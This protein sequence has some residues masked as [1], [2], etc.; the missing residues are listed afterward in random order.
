[1]LISYHYFIITIKHIS[2]KEIEHSKIIMELQQR[3]QLSDISFSKAFFQD[4]VRE[5][6]FITTMMK[7]Y[8]AAQLKILSEISNIC[9]RHSINWFA[10]CGTLIG[11]V[12]HGGYVPWDDDMDIC[13]LRSDWNRFF[14]VAKE[15]LP[16]GYEVL[17]IEKEVEYK[18]PI[19]RIVNSHAID[20]SPSH[21][22]KFYGCP[23]TIGIDIFP[24]D[25]IYDDE[26]REKDR[27]ERA[28]AAIEAY[29]NN[30]NEKKSRKLLLE[31]EKTYRE[32]PGE[33][34]KKVGL[35]PFYIPNGNHI[36]DKEL[37]RTCIEIPF[38]N[39]YV[40]V[41]AAYNSV[42]SIEYGDYLKV[43]KGGGEHG[44]PVYG[45]QEKILRNAIKRNPYRYTFDKEELIR[46]IKRYEDKKHSATIN[47]RHRKVVFLPC[48]AKWWHSMET[49]WKKMKAD[50]DNEVHVMPIAYYD[51][52]YNGGVYGMHDE[53]KEFPA[54]VNTESVYKYDFEKEKPETIVVQVPFDEWSSAITVH[55]YFYSGNILQYT[56]ELV[57]VPCYEADDPVTYEDKASVAISTLIEQPVVINADKIVL[58]TEKM[59]E[60]YIKKLVEL[61]GEEYKS[62]WQQKI[63]LE[64]E[65]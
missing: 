47:N 1:M 51:C 54:Y 5:G 7:R 36:Y 23:Y 40:R 53:S 59:R 22:E 41:P 38:E 56:D 46:S 30:T 49:L 44:Y 20:Y 9:D 16:E 48:R 65:F 42:L 50:P 63:I 19:G 57:Y 61:S 26:E 11:G 21:L 64:E 18:E 62:Y 45:E 33:Q 43:V 4:E 58:K 34:A 3:V 37:F 10:D 12:R 31:I 39:T 52:D 35:M 24:L 15:E 27:V 60:L 2:K 17:T 14:E 28:R 55:E 25:N 8:W 29:K 13:M 32:C 6:F